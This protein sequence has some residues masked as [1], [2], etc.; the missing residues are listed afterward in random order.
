MNIIDYRI[1]SSSNRNHHPGPKGLEAEVTGLIE[2]GFTT[3]GSP[4]VFKEAICQAMIKVR[5]VSSPPDAP[6]QTSRNEG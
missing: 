3:H 2:E 5:Q 6:S 1:A 4:F